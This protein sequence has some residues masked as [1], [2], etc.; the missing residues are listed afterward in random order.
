MF[1]FANVVHFFPDK[2]ARLRGGRFPFALIS[3]YSSHGF[4][5]WHSSF[6]SSSES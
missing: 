2:L 3:F 6:L 1:A 4:F 5:L